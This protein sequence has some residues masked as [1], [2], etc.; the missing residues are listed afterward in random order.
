[1]QSRSEVSEVKTSMYACLRAHKGLCT[2][3]GEPDVWAICK[4]KWDER[5]A[6]KHAAEE[7]APWEVCSVSF[8]GA[9]DRAE[10]QKWKG[11]LICF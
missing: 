3:V 4:S 11:L 7:K 8:L 5:K 10:L 6:E 9:A 1:M 2:W